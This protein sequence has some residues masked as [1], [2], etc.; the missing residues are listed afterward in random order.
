MYQ[1]S[2]H[3]WSWWSCPSPG[4]RCWRKEWRRGW[5][6]ARCCWRGLGWCLWIGSSGAEFWLDSAASCLSSCKRDHSPT[7]LLALCLS[8]QCCI[9]PCNSLSPSLSHCS[10]WIKEVSTMYYKYPLIPK[11]DSK[12]IFGLFLKTSLCRV[13]VQRLEG[14]T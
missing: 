2:T 9:C 7:L 3:H 12:I 8:V 6:A 4:G 14:R 13:K 1:W 5:R 11:L 10:K